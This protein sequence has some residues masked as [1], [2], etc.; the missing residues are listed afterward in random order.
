MICLGCQNDKEPS[1][2]APKRRRCKAC[3][4]TYAVDF[5]RNRRFMTK[6]GITIEQHDAMRVAQNNSCDICN[7]ELG[8]GKQVHVDHDHRNGKVRALLCAR[9]NVGLGMFNDVV[10]LRRAADYLERHRG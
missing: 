10:A 8:H 4:A 1:E 3:W 6:Y 9:C 5:D 2:F 7:G